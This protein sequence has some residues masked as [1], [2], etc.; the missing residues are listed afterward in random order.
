VAWP[1][2]RK[3][4]A[5]RFSVS[6]PWRDPS[7]CARGGAT[8]RF[9]RAAARP[10]RRERAVAQLFGV[11]AR[12]V[13]AR[14]GANKGE[15]SANWEVS[16]PFI[17]ILFFVFCIAFVCVVWTRAHFPTVQIAKKR[18]AHRAFR[19]ETAGAA[20]A[21]RRSVESQRRIISTVVL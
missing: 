19:E 21:G 13:A 4:A 5:R 2:Q 8:I 20:P 16:L 14:Q 10:F 17:L 3:R 11:S 6:A 1:L 7:A 12:G 9:V 18:K 15:R